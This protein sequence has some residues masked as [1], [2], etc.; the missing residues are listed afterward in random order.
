MWAYED[1]ISSMAYNL[2]YIL[3]K[4][5]HLCFSLFNLFSFMD[6]GAEMQVCAKPNEENVQVNSI[7]E[8]LYNYND[9]DDDD[10]N[11]SI[12]SSSS[13]SDNDD[14]ILL[15]NYLAGIRDMVSAPF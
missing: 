4:G 11:I 5:L 14:D 3:K 1:T 15:S 8:K 6:K 7:H 12:Y 2:K 9:D 10:E 13:W